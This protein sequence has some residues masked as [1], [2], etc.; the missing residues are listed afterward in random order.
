MHSSVD[1]HLGCFYALAIVN[2][3]TMNIEMHISF[4]IMIFS[5]YKP[6]M[7]LLGCMVA[8]FLFF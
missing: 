5:G 8:L 3:T 4:H 1:G 7:G 6:R 2:S